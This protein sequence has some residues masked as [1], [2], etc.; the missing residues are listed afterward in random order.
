M[1]G[2]H[3]VGTNRCRVGIVA[4]VVDR[5]I[6]VRAGDVRRG[7]GRRQRRGKLREAARRN[8]VPGKRQAG[9]RIGDRREPGEVAGQLLRVRHNR[10]QRLSRCRSQP[11]IA[12]EEEEPIVH[13]RPAAGGAGLRA[14]ARFLTEVVGR[15]GARVAHVV[16]GGAARTVRSRLRHDRNDGLSLAVFGGERIPQHVHFLHRVERRVQRQVVES[17]RAHVDAVDGVVRGTVAAA[18][19][20][21]V[22]TPAAARRAKLRAAVEG[23]RRH[24]G[25]QGRERQQASSGD[26]QVLDLL[27]GDGLAH[28]RVG[29]LQQRG[30]PDDRDVF[31]D[32]RQAERDG[33]PADLAV[34]QR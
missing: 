23:L 7:D 34:A 8:D 31:G 1:V 26:R 27:L 22:L 19:D 13:Q 33:R 15:L 10:E 9:Q 11:L 6:V 2:Q 30:H 21:H 18:L 25:R 17:Q 16:V 12:A 24:A 28:R 3:L 20:G 14:I 4:E 5:P 32:V 29:R